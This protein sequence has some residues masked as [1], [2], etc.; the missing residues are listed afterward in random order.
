LRFVYDSRVDTPSGVSFPGFINDQAAR[1][2]NFLF[3][4]TYTS[5]SSFTNEFRFSYGRLQ[6]DIPRPSPRSVP[7]ARTLPDLVITN[8]ASPAGLGSVDRAQQSLPETQT[9]D[10]APTF[11]YGVEFL[12]QIASKRAWS[13]TT[14]SRVQD[15][16]GSRPSPIPRDWR[17]LR[18]LNSASRCSPPRFH[19]R[20]F[21]D[22]WK[23][24]R[25]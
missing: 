3:A 6:A 16:S 24:H 13:K 25:P 15:A 2:L 20:L 19:S 9:G 17:T 8:V 11:R 22:I 5:S 10:R 18:S 1:N 14:G 7:E 21:P 12:G 23:A 4:D